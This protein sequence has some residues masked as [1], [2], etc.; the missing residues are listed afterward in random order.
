M[1]WIDK[2]TRE[3][4]VG[5]V[6]FLYSLSASITAAVLYGILDAPELWMGLVVALA[7]IVLLANQ[8]LLMRSQVKALDEVLRR[9]LRHSSLRNQYAIREGHF[10]DEKRE[11]AT[12]VVREVLPR[13]VE[14]LESG[15]EVTEIRIV[16]DSGTTITPIFPELVRTGVKGSV[17]EI[18][19][20]T[21]NLAGIDEIHA[22]DQLDTQVI[23]EEHIHLLGGEPLHT[24]RAT[25][26]DKTLAELGEVWLKEGTAHARSIGIITANWLLLGHGYDRLSL[27]ARGRG[28]LPFKQAIAETAD[29]VLVVAPLGK[30]LAMDNSDIKDLNNWLKESEFKDSYPVPFSFPN[31][32]KSSIHL[33]TS[34]RPLGAASPLGRSSERLNAGK[35]STSDWPEN[36]TIC[37]ESPEYT[38][39]VGAQELIE[40]EMPHVYIRRNAKQAFQLE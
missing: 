30:L 33:L 26:G 16:L 17:S 6:T 25:T 19:L 13:I 27:C 22:L 8:R 3:H 37:P 32:R 10:T 31:N 2:K 40:I 28:H 7:A 34:L 18:D 38:P 29:I 36:F 21:N 1:D 35:R 12:R 9:R 14:D 23:T 15:G 11:L 39:P 5:I 4:R 20:Y 24:Y